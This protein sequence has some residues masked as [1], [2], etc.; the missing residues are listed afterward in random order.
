[1]TTV[2]DGHESAILWEGF[3]EDAVELVIED[4]YL[5]GIRSVTQGDNG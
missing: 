3:D 1:M 5:V 4:I 2:E